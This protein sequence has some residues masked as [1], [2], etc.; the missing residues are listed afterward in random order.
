MASVRPAAKGL[1][2]REILHLWAMEMVAEA[3]VLDYSIAEP[4][5]PEVITGLTPRDDLGQEAL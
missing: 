3:N 4:H 2:S 5:A 1:R